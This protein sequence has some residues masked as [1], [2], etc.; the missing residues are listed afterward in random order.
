[1]TTIKDTHL[2]TAACLWEAALDALN[3]ARPVA[4]GGFEDRLRQYQGNYGTAQLRDDVARLAVACDDAW[5]ALDPDE[6]DDAG[7]F[8]W[9]FC[10]SWLEENFFKMTGVY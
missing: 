7:S 8:D 2:F 5:D 6:Q 3:V 4:K 1:M 10:P 9:E